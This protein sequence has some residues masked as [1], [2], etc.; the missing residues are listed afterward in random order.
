M[1]LKGLVVFFLF[2]ASLVLEGCSAYDYYESTI[3]LD[4]ADVH[5]VKWQLNDSTKYKD[6]VCSD[7]GREP[8]FFSIKIGLK[9]KESND[10]DN[11]ESSV[12]T[13]YVAIYGCT[14][15]GCKRAEKIMIHNEDYSYTKLLKKGD[16]KISVP[17]GDFDTNDFGYDCDVVKDYFFHLKI[18][19]DDIKI[20]LDAQKGTETCYARSNPWCI[21]C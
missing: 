17:D 15:Y 16:F 9:N 8:D 1:K 20:D 19:K 11:Q 14:D 3:S 10:G 6:V 13:L 21:Y 5:S 12:D 7:I 2:S 4:Q 18:D